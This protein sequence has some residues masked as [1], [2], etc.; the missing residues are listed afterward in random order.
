[1]STTIEHV[2]CEAAATSALDSDPV[3]V[4]CQHEFS[5]GGLCARD[6]LPGATRCSGHREDGQPDYLGRPAQL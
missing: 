3:D 1:M 5:S 6:A 2:E 4:L